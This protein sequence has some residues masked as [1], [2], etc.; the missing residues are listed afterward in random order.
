VTGRQ[1]VIELTGPDSRDRVRELAG[2]MPRHTTV[3]FTLPEAEPEP[4]PEGRG[5]GGYRKVTASRGVNRAG[6]Q[7]EF[8]SPRGNPRG[9]NHSK[10]GHFVGFFSS[11]HGPQLA[12][13]QRAGRLFAQKAGIT[14]REPQGHLLQARVRF[15]G[16]MRPRNV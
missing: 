5:G 13:N 8:F 12:P 16:N 6:S 9:G 1:I 10:A 3:T 4:E 14:G 7:W 11:A 2:V 15:T